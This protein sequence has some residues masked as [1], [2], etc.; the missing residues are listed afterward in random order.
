MKVGDLVKY[1]GS[2]LGAQM[3]IIVRVVLR[4]TSARDK[5]IIEWLPPGPPAA[6]EL[7]ANRLELVSESTNGN[8]E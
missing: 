7:S 1:K 5:Y 8:K 4:N 3:G 2:R 6:S